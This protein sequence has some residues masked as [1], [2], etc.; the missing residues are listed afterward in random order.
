[1]QEGPVRSS[2]PGCLATARH[3]SRRAALTGDPKRAF[4]VRRSQL[5]GLPFE[6]ANIPLF[7]SFPSL[8]AKNQFEKLNQKS[9]VFTLVT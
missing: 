8:L 9:H 6:T 5:F 3:P 1:M 7:A 4:Q 2:T